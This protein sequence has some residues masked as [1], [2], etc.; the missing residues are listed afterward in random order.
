MA[1][2]LLRG[3]K[4]FSNVRSASSRSDQPAQAGQEAPEAARRTKK[5]H[6]LTA[7]LRVLEN[8]PGPVR[9]QILRTRVHLPRTRFRRPRDGIPSAQGQ[10]PPPSDEVAEATRHVPVLS[11]ADIA[12]HGGDV[13]AEAL[14]APTALSSGR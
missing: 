11:G 12:D 5:T 4:S 7:E 14:R 9:Q 10:L 1:S 13:L 2:S 8:E 6:D 3:H